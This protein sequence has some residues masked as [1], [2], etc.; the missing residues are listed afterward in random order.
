[1]AM[2]VLVVA[3]RQ[4]MRF[5]QNIN[6]IHPP[7]FLMKMPTPLRQGN[8]TQTTVHPLAPHLSALQPQQP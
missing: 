2:T 8:A 7:P 3:Y 6:N 4:I 5:Y 1:M